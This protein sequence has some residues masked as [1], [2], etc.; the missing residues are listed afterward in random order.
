M[1]SLPV[2]LVSFITCASI[3]NSS[4]LSKICILSVTYTTRFAERGKSDLSCNAVNQHATTM[5]CLAL[6]NKNK[7][8]TVGVVYINAS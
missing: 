6:Q 7:L 5:Y 1:T 3:I 2:D 8:D 4:T